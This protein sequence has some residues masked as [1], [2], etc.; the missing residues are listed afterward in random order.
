MIRASPC[1]PEGYY[2]ALRPLCDWRG[3]I[4][5][6]AHEHV[7]AKIESDVQLRVAL[8]HVRRVADRQGRGLRKLRAPELVDKP[9]PPDIPTGPSPHARRR[10]RIA[11]A[12]PGTRPAPQRGYYEATTRLLR[13]CYQATTRLLPGAARAPLGQAAPQQ[14]PSSSAVSYLIYLLSYLISKRH[15]KIRD[16]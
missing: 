7:D 10:R 9:P 14:Q 5:I 16:R 15:Y 6:G 4:R 1:T 3:E 11:T 12:S 8:A 13:G 2:T